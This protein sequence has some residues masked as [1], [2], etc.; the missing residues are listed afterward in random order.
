M[1]TRKRRNY[2]PSEKVQQKLIFKFFL[3]QKKPFVFCA[4]NLYYFSWESDFLGYSNL[5]FLHE[6]EIKRSASDFKK[7]FSKVD[8]H[9]LLMNAQ[10]NLGKTPNY[11]WYCMPAGMVPIGDIPW[12]AGLFYVKNK[13]IYIVKNAPLLHKKRFLQETVATKFAKSLSSRYFNKK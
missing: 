9:N 10:A 7:D 11:F 8:K 13:K 1:V 3:D 5:G 6:V 12:Y 4:P 2:A